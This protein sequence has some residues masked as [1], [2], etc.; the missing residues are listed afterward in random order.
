MGQDAVGYERDI[1]PL[2]RAKD[3][4][5]MRMRFD[6]S[7]YGD[8]SANADGIL[9]KLADGSMP[10]DGAWPEEQVETFRKWVAAGCPA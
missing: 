3:I 8:V 1:R 10:C 6:L 4:S 5:A 9:A 7:S 2:F